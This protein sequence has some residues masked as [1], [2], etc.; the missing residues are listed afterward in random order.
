MC[1][2]SPH[3]V[4]KTTTAALLILMFANWCERDGIDWK[5]VTTASSWR[6]LTRYLWPEVRKWAAK[7]AQAKWK[8][9]MSRDLIQTTIKGQ[10]GTGFAVAS[11]RPELIEGAHAD[12][13]LYVL[14]E[15]KAIPEKTWDAVEGAFASGECYAY[16]ISTPGPPAGRFY[17]IHRRRPGTLDWAVHHIT[18]LDGVEAGRIS[19][20][21]IEQRK[22][23]WGETS[24]VYLQRVTGE[25][26]ADQEC[27]VIPLAYVEA[28]T[29][30]WKELSERNAWP[31]H[32]CIGADIAR[33]TDGDA[34]TLAV[35]RG[36]A[37]E[38]IEKWR[39]ADTMETTGRIAAAIRD[40]G[41]PAVVDVVGLG[42]GV[43][44]R[45]REQN[46]DAVEFNG[47]AAAWHE[48]T[49]DPSLK[50]RF[51]NLRARAYWH[52]RELLDPS[53]GVEVAL[54]DDDELV[55]DLTA[56]T[57]GATSRGELVVEAKE[58]I[59][60]R[61]GRSPDK[62]DAVVQAFALEALTLTLPTDLW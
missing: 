31:D 28:A 50:R 9:N 44:D 18:A 11:N 8:I 36:N 38:R 13:L 51:A 59:R 5:I 46:L 47:G 20:E 34:S 12:R 56:P 14:D 1:V 6:Q 10:Y 40:L 4:G 15:A 7:V 23:Q 43:Y 55:A 33:S 54:P 35:R 39:V 58:R 32:T 17:D 30:R 3:G 16:A 37:I 53:S 24:A 61:L 42:A 57:Y 26:A 60:A 48:N 29:D 62:G 45:L 19:Q 49:D 22:R 52:L 21:W 2:R 25:F 27:G 41:V